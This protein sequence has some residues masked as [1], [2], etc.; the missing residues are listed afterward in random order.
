MGAGGIA[1]GATPASVLAGAARAATE[2]ATLGKPGVLEQLIAEVSA[3][4]PSHTARRAMSTHRDAPPK[5]DIR[6]FL[7]RPA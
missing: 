5:R 7:I 3:A 2:R 1:L 4:M 6:I